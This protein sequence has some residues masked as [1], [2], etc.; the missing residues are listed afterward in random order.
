[1]TDPSLI[2][3]MQRSQERIREELGKTRFRGEALEVIGAP[4][5]TPRFTFWQ[6]FLEP[7]QSHHVTL[8]R[9]TRAREG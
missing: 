1:M 4:I 9:R 8:S 5:H 7:R 2:V 3:A 6:R